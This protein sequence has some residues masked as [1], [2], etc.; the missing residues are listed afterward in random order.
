MLK[1]EVLSPWLAKQGFLPTLITLGEGAG[2]YANII[3]S[4]I[5]FYDEMVSMIS[6]GRSRNST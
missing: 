1:P 3:R 2:P 4:S 5:P 6:E